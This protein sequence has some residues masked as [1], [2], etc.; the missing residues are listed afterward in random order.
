MAL[1]LHW[2]AGFVSVVVSPGFNKPEVTRNDNSTTG[3][4]TCDSSYPQELSTISTPLGTTEERCSNSWM[5]LRW[6]MVVHP[7][8]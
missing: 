7:R 3:H 4:S 2:K 8:L 5:F 1:V 6:R